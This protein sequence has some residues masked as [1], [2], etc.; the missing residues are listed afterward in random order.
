ML[1]ISSIALLLSAVSA[2]NVE[3]NSSL[4]SRSSGKVLAILEGFADLG[5]V[6]SPMQIPELTIKSSFTVPTTARCIVI[7]VVQYMIIYTALA[8]CRTVQEFTGTGKGPI[9]AGLSAA[10]QTLTYGPMICVLFIACRMR[11]EFLSGGKGQPQIWVQNC[12]YAMTFSVLASALLVLLIPLVTGKPMPLKDDSCDLEAPQ[13][14]EFKSKT[15]FYVLSTMR[16]LILLGLYGGLIGVIVGISTYLPPGASDLSKLPPPAPA[17]RC[18]MV[19]AVVFFATQLVIAICRSYCEF[20]GVELT[21]LVGIMNGAAAT[22]EF[23]PMLAIVFLSARMRALQHNSQPHVWAQNC[24]YAATCALCL[25]TILS[26]VVPAFLPG[27]VKRCQRTKELTFDMPAT[28]LGYLLITLRFLCMLGF[29]CGVAGV[30][31]SIYTFEA[32]SG[33]TLPVST[34]VQCVVNLSCQFFFVYLVLSVC[35]TVK[36]VMGAAFPWRGTNYTPLLRLAK[37]RLDSLPCWRFS[38]SQHACMH[39]SSQIG[40]VRRRLGSR[41]ACAWPLGLCS[42]RS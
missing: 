5:H 15:G 9:E 16:Y 1:R 6:E 11:V 24:M 29:Y 22:V 3:R 8:I 42:S 37:R 28:M 26:I 14:S 4:S 27:T 10:A 17:V 36:E 34:T 31:S 40:K 2:I 30:I 21:E 39:C 20:V 7:M 41:M 35:M 12:M 32:P 13:A 23:A 19:L 18:T 25:T 33:P 38:S